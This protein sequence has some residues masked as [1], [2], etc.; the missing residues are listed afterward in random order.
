MKDITP[1]Q[2]NLFQVNSAEALKRVQ[3]ALDFLWKDP[4]KSIHDKVA[5]DFDY[6]ELLAAL[7]SAKAA[8]VEADEFAK[9]EDE[10]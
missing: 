1:Q 2:K 6:E 10:D 7:L 8:L 4:K 9:A 5:G 3:V